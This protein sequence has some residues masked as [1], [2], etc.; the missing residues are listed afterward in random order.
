MPV[1]FLVFHAFPQSLDKHIVDPAAFAVHADPDAVALNQA[2]EL[3]AGKLAALISVDDRRFPMA[4]NGK[5][6]AEP[7]SQE[8]NVMI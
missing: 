5:R 2:D 1:D 4:L 8:K 7:H 3:P 6:L